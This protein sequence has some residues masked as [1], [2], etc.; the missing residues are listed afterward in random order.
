M[1]ALTTGH[2]RR[3]WTTATFW[4]TFIGTASLIYCQGD[5]QQELSSWLQQQPGIAVIARDL[6]GIYAEGA[7]TGAPDAVHVADRFHPP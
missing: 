2:E 1:W 7:S 3:H 5:A 4:L 6:C